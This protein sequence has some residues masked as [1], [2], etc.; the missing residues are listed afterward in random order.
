[1]ATSLALLHAR[2]LLHRDLSPGNART[3]GDGCNFGALAT[4]GASQLLVGTPSVV[5]PE[6]LAGAPL[7]QRADL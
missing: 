2:R 7:D 5:P 6:A 1:M 4:F 3:T